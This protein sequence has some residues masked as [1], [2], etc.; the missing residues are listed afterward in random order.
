M[1]FA[2]LVACQVP[3]VEEDQ[4]QL[5][6]A[7]DAPEFRFCHHR[8]ESPGSVQGWCELLDDAP[9]DKCPGMRETCANPGDVLEAEMGALP[10]RS[11]ESCGGQFD[12]EPG[13]VAG[14]ASAPS[15]PQR[16]EPV[17]C[18]Q[19]FDGAGL[20]RIL[21]W[22]AAFAVAIALL[23]L[24]RTLVRTFGVRGAAREAPPEAEPLLEEDEALPDVPNLPSA[25]LLAAAKEALGTGNAG[26]A[27]LL[28]RGAALRR[29]GEQSRLRLHRSRTDR[30]YVRALRKEPEAQQ[31][32]RDVVGAVEHHRWGGDPLGVERAQRALA[33]AERLLATVAG[34]LLLLVFVGVSD[35]R[36]QMNGRHDPSGDAAL[37]SVL[38]NHG[39]DISMRLR[40][41]GDLDDEVD[42]M[43]LDLQFVHP[44][45]EHWESIR[46]WVRA[47]GVLVVAGEPLYQQDFEAPVFPGL[48][49]RRWLEDA[50]PA[51][52]APEVQG[53]G[54]PTP[55]WSGGARAVFTLGEPWVKAGEEGA[56]VSV[57]EE[58]Q[59]IVVAIADGRLLWNGSFVVPANEVFIGELL[60]AGQA[61]FGWALPSPARVQ[62]ATTTAV[63]SPS[64]AGASDPFD[65]MW[66]SNLWLMMLHVLGVWALAGLWLGW[67]FTPLR[68][69]PS[70]GR[71]E[72]SEHVTALGTRWFRLGASRH[73]LVQ[74]ARLWLARLGPS[75]LQLAARRSG[76]TPAQA[77]Q[78]VAELQALVDD[79]LGP[80]EPSDLE[81]MEELWKVTH[82][83]A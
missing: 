47:G 33:A 16:I 44:L 52:L 76:R 53:L 70:E 15:Q 71:L 42:A 72:F 69:P 37:Y 11:G 63:I 9:R 41:L 54:L 82:P 18:D 81:R 79:P 46:E 60:Y 23:L 32:L 73:A 12:E 7:L 62:I 50:A 59:G 78:W 43:V 40:S 25:D 24:G 36:A 45:D 38:E 27:V 35:A 74:M 10:Q 68:D 77:A 75:G 2:M 83:P 29:L 30:E 20:S 14:E 1:L 55:V 51:Q 5:E 66:E 39:Y 4:P 57:L 19:A 31:D 8:S 34:L 80:D 61:A 67:P 17:G 56:V 6:S 48:G 28:A 13:G 64:G 49:E 26:E 21:T 58:G 65:S 22:V 3:Q